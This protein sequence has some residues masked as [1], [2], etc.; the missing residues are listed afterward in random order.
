MNI[1]SET[2]I[3]AVSRAEK[4]VAEVLHLQQPHEVIRSLIPTSPKTIYTRAGEA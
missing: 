2:T 4:G 1:M 3:L